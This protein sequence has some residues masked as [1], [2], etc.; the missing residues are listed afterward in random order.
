M[1]CPPSQVKVGIGKGRK[2]FCI[3][4]VRKMLTIVL[5]SVRI[6]T[7]IVLFNKLNMLISLRNCE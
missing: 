4:P 3:C 1:C 5:M 2:V 6:L 7:Y